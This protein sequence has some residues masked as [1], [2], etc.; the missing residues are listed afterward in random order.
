M[1]S[2]L[3]MTKKEKLILYIAVI[4]ISLA[5]LDRLVY[6]P[7]KGAFTELQEKTLIEEKKVGAN[8]RNLMQKDAIFKEY[9]KLSP[10][11]GTLGSDEEEMAK[12]LKA[13]EEKSRNSNVYI[14]DIKPQPA[15]DIKFYK[16]YVV[17]TTVEAEMTQIISFIYQLESM[18]QL[19]NIEELRLSADKEGS[20]TQKARVIITKILIPDKS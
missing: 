8:I 2:L 9:E 10:Y 16:K 17:E 11:A 6:R 1:L 7:I 20:K 19:I 4:F 15:I 18:D 5:F 3:K 13:I 12:F 14:A